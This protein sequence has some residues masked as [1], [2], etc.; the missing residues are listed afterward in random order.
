[1]TTA[2]PPIAPLLRITDLEV[3]YRGEGRSWTPAV[4]GVGLHVEPGEFVTLVG[5]SG[6][7]KTTVI[8]GALGL[9][10]AAA[11][12]TAGSIEYSGVDVT[13]WPEQRMARVRGAYVGFIPQDPGTSLNPVKRIG[14]Q[15]IEAVK[16]NERERGDRAGHIEQALTS[17]RTAG[18]GDAER[19]F[20]QYPHELS[21]G[22]KQ[23]ALIAIALAG[24]PRI[25][26]ADE[27][28][29]ALDVTVQRTILDHLERLRT[30][31]GI[32]ILLVTHD[33]G[34]AL[35]RS[36]RILVMQ[37]GRLVEE[38]SVHQLLVRPQSD[39]TR[40]LLDAAPA[41]HAGRLAAS[42]GLGPR[43]AH[44]DEIV[45]E[46]RGLSKHYALRRRGPAVP[47]LDGVD[48]VVRAGTT[49]AIVGES[50]A[51]KSTLA[52]ILGGFTAADAGTVRIAGRDVTGARPRELREVRRELQ[53][54]FQNPYASLDPRFTVEEIVAEPLRA[55]RVHSERRDLDARVRELL[56][57]VALDPAFAK[58]RPRQLSGGQRQRVAIARALALNPRILVLD[59]AVSALDV[60]VQ[61][62]ILQL[63][64]DLQTELGLSYVFVTHDLG[65]VRLIADD[66]TV[67]RAG[68]VVESGSAGDVLTDPQHEYTRTL[69]ESIPGSGLFPAEVGA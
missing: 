46:A 55:F 6:S 58:R 69:L 4:R 9:L 36:D 61:A 56:D 42:P 67:M 34:V 15:V 27:P 59:E 39:Y 13:R 11:R 54:V 41:R 62:Q 8:H 7:G 68:R 45:V 60:S 44:L 5:E 30:E 48:L 2:A 29:S 64:V 24:K 3:D 33:L 38:G 49:H 10:P 26:V 19:V 23:R 18:L 43:T 66:V 50:G 21:G 14:Q 52:G 63:L 40:R 20:H 53:F 51:G 22:M 28:T 1:M 17:L 65:V 37:D 35:D 57:A 16:L 31:L 32:G 12:V 25:I 47:A